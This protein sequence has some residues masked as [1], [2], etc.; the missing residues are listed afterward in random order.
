M[1]ESIGLQERYEYVLHD[2]DSSFAK[3][4]DESIGRFGIKVLKSPPRSPM[5]NVFVERL[6]RSVKYEEVYL[7]AYES[8]ADA[9]SGIGKYFFCFITAAGLIQRLTALPRIPCTST[10]SRSRRLHNLRSS[11]YPDREICL[12]LWDHL[13][14]RVETIW[15][16]SEG[17]PEPWV[18]GTLAS[19]DHRVAT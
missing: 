7:R 11:T 18:G 8:V 5:A 19:Q 14:I 17:M 12:N 15:S 10:R 13:S 16:P 6:W 2:R 4:L 9:K 3:H 1:R